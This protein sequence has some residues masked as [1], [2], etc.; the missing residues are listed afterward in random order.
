MEIRCLTFDLDNTLW[1]IEPVIRRAEKEFYAWL[2]EHCPEIT[3][4]FEM[5]ELA[6]QRYEYFNEFPQQRHNLTW[7]RKQ[8]LAKIFTEFGYEHMDVESAFHYYW[9]FRNDV[10]LFPGTHEILEFLSQRYRVGVITNGNACV[11]MI[12]INNYF[13]FVISSEKIGAA[14]PAPE[15]FDAALRAAGI[16]A[17]QV[18]HI[19]DDPRIDI[20][21]ASA[22]GFKTI[23][24]NPKLSPWPGGQTP[25]AVVRSLAELESALE[26]M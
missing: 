13:D 12:G 19:G 22:M 1:A 7:L 6:E 14:K 15:I 21:G 17:S 16:P 3:A 10:E 25:N 4:R 24:Y 2:G 23:W 5:S 18:V 26:R 11:E 20:L 8:W 9:R